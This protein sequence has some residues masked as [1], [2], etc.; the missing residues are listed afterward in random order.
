MVIPLSFPIL[1]GYNF[2]SLE[3]IEGFLEPTNTGKST[4]WAKKVARRFNCHVSLGYPEIAQA[5]PGFAR[6]YKRYNASILISPAGDIVY[7]YRKRFLYYTD[8]T[9]ADEGDDA[10]FTIRHVAGL[11]RE[12][13]ERVTMGICMYARTSPGTAVAS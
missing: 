9:W 13:G 1:V 7:H 8:E 12:G 4:D 10:D 2:P 6:P 11:G 3:A 5:P